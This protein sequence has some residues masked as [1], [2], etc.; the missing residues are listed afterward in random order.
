LLVTSTITW[1]TRRANFFELVLAVQRDYEVVFCVPLSRG[2]EV[3][4]HSKWKIV[5][6]DG[7]SGAFFTLDRALP[8]AN[9]LQPEGRKILYSLRV[10]MD[11]S[12]HQNPSDVCNPF[13]A[14]NHNLLYLRGS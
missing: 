14:E 2:G 7:G 5:V 4:R 6:A 3:F 11:S 1:I 10:E 13:F 9:N 8:A 12:V